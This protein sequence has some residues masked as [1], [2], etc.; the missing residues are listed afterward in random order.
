M[1]PIMY[2]FLLGSL[3]VT[4]LTNIFSKLCISLSL[5]RSIILMSCCSQMLVL[6]Y[7]ARPPP[8]EL[9]RWGACMIGGPSDLAEQIRVAE[10]GGLKEISLL[11]PIHVFRD[12]MKEFA[13]EVIPLV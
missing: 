2:D 8:F 13:E 4:I 6:T 9:L 11:P 12:V 5:R 10:S 3:F 7:I 1:L